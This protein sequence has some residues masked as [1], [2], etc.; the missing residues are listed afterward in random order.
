M[1]NDS[2]IAVA[3]IGGGTIAPLHAKYLLSSPTC[4]LVAIIDPF[5]PGRNL[6][7]S[8]SV[9][10]FSSVPDLLSSPCKTPEAYIICVPSGLHVSVASD[11]LK[12]AAPKAIL[13]EKPLSTDSSSGV[14]LLDLANKKPCKVVV[15]HHRR[16]HPS[17][18]ATKQLIVSGKI[19]KITAISGLWTCK[20]ND[21][22][23]TLAK[24]RYSR[25]S[26]GGPVWTNFVHDIDALHYLAGSRIVR[27]WVTGT[28]S[29][30]T[31]EGAVEED[32]VEEGAAMLLQFANGVVGTFVLSDN[33]ASPYGWDAATGEN[34]SYPKAEG[35][36]DSYRIF[37]TEGTVSAPDGI[38][39]TYKD[40]EA[41]KRGLEVG[42]NVPM[43]REVMKVND[44]I[45]FQ[46]Q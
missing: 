7:Q 8:L 21:G 30:R 2:K 34:P 27:V 18:D 1:S 26:G 43:T 31:H 14:Q 40:G 24:W 22:Y 3:L 5:P 32:L 19:G 46:A 25:S 44:G 23:F 33:V 11:I 39:W 20:K 10:H 28:L 41:E 13:V 6:A 35:G 42:W 45:P 38:V 15:G 29:R 16:F 12:L 37:G 36:V 17:L 9:P 4:E